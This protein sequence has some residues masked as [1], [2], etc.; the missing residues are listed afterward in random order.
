MQDMFKKEDL[1]Y[2]E[3][4][5]EKNSNYEDEIEDLEEDEEFEQEYEDE[6]EY[7]KDIT[8]EEDLIIQDMADFLKIFGDYSRIKI[9]ECIIDYEETVED[10]A[11]F[12]GLSHSIVS[13]HLKVLRQAKLIVGK[14]E[15]KYVYYKVSDKHVQK[16]YD[17]TRAHIKEFKK[18]I[19][20]GRE[21]RELARMLEKKIDSGK[22]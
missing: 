16:I 18:T 19:S 11:L 2:E 1:L 22:I 6:G 20:A 3:L 8:N 9:L 14:R 5:D 12:T 7:G 21:H 13:Y 4:E 10:I 15:G 17:L